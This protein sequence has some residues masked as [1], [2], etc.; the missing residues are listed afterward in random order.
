MSEGSRVV[1]RLES[2]PRH[3]AIPD[4]E[5]GRTTGNRLEDF[6]KAHLRLHGTRRNDEI[7]AA[8]CN[9]LPRVSQQRAIASQRFDARAQVYRDIPARPQV[10]NSLPA[11]AHSQFAG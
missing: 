9:V 10:G 4:F 8:N 5:Y 2:G 3:H 1:Y 6:G 11:R 7:Q